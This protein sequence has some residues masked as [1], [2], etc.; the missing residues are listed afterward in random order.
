MAGMPE[1]PNGSGEHPLC[2]I[3]IAASDVAASREFYSKVFGWQMFDESLEYQMFMPAAGPGGAIVPAGPERVQ[4]TVPFIYG[5]DLPALVAE[6]EAHGGTL[7]QQLT[8]VPP[9][10]TAEFL[11]QAGTR[12]GLVNMAPQLPVPHIPTVFGDAPKPPTGTICSIE[13]YGGDLAV[14]RE[15][16][17]GVLGWGVL[18]TMPQYMGFNPG[19]GIGGVFQA[20]TAVAKSM[21][22]IWVEDVNQSLADIE[23]AGGK[24]M[25]DPMALPGFGTFGYFTDPCGTAMGLLGP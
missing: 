2:W 20:H 18:D 12:F 3:E 13:L 9:A 10:L 24:R 21:P 7:V 5:A 22:Y 15:F 6:I 1:I 23:A 17:G 14:A 11:D 25:G 4:G 8:D 16:F 19:A